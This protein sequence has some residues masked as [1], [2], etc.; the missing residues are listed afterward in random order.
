M[1]KVT[2]I[3]PAKNKRITVPVT[4]IN[5]NNGMYINVDALIDTGANQTCINKSYADVIGLKITKEGIMHG[6]HGKSIST[7]SEALI[8]LNVKDDPI[9]LDIVILP[10]GLYYEA[11]LGMDILLR[12]DVSIK[13]KDGITTFTFKY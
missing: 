1:F 12:G 4:F 8:S 9:M 7:I 13:T 6:A 2:A 11:V 3:A 10:D 5:P